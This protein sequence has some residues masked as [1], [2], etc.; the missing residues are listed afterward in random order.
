[1]RHMIFRLRKHGAASSHRSPV[2]S[3]GDAACRIVISK[4]SPN[5]RRRNTDHESA[6]TPQDYCIPLTDLFHN[7]RLLVAPADPQEHVFT[8]LAPLGRAYP[9]RQGMAENPPA[10]NGRLQRE[11]PG[12]FALGE[13]VFVLRTDEIERLSLSPAERE[14][15]RPYYE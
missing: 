14:L 9:T 15:L 3:N 8:R 12:R 7:G 6:A 1:G 2:G 13:G 5:P 10:I 11:F 4:R